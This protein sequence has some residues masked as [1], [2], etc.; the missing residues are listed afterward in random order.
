MKRADLALLYR[1]LDSSLM[2]GEQNRLDTAFRNDPHLR[3]EYEKLYRLRSLVEGQKPPSF[4]KGFPH[5]V[6][7]RVNLESTFI[8]VPNFQDLLSFMFR[9]VVLVVSIAVILLLTYN[10]AAS[11]DFSL[12]ASF[13]LPAGLH[14]EDLYDARIVLEME[15]TL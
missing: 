3:E 12:T 1:S 8:A 7:N 6:M 5:R 2:P 4:R 13:G 15:G 10:L 11:G 9:R 14:P